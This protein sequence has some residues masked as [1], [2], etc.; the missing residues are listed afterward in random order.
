VSVYEGFP[1]RSLGWLSGRLV[2]N[3][4]ERTRDIKQRE[5]VV[6][7]KSKYTAT[8]DFTHETK[9]SKTKPAK[10]TRSIRTRIRDQRSIKSSSSSREPSCWIE[11]DEESPLHTLSLL[12]FPSLIAIASSSSPT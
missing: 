2:E 5:E 7:I 10:S 11:F 12:L 8:V 9:P 3:I 1:C 6:Y 4:A